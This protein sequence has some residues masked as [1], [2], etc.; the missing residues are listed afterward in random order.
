MRPG[1]GGGP[2]DIHVQQLAYLHVSVGE[3][4][5]EEAVGLRSIQG[6]TESMKKLLLASKESR[7][8]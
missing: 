7:W 6:I 3:R 1:Q 4:S 2:K 8:A 5:L